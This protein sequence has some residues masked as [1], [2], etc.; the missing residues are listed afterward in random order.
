MLCTV[1]KEW[2]KISNITSGYFWVVCFFFNPLHV[3]FYLFIGIALGPHC[4]FQ[5][6]SNCGEWGLLFLVVPGLQ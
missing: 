5:I 4:C 2:K 1:D 3:L 6:F